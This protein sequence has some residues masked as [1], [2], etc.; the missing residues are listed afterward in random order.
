MLPLGFAE[1]QLKVVRSHGYWQSDVWLAPD[2]QHLGAI[3]K[4]KCLALAEKIWKIFH[5]HKPH[6]RLCRSVHKCVFP[7]NVAPIKRRNRFP[8]SIKCIAKKHCHNKE[9]MNQTQISLLLVFSSK[10]TFHNYALHKCSKVIMSNWICLSRL[11]KAWDIYVLLH[12]ISI[13]PASSNNTTNEKYESSLFSDRFT[14]S[15]ICGIDF[16]QPICH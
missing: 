13:L 1:Y 14:V 8:N 3:A 9:V 11:L 2:C 16:S 6:A 12:F 4:K 5:G 7:T 15:V 10:V